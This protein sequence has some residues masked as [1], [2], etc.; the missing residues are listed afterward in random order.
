MY[1]VYVLKSKQD[2]RLYIGSTSDLE[3]RLFYHNSGKVRSTQSRRPLDVIYK[4]QYTS[5]TETRKRENFLK[6]GQ[7]RKL[8]LELIDNWW[9]G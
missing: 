3:K 5:I 6:S 4:E 8:L 1:W 2:G 9:G 7:G